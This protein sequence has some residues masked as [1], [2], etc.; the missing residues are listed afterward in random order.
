MIVK[1]LVVGNMQANCYIIENDDS[2]II[3]DPGAEIS[4]IKETITKEVKGVL[5][6]HSHTDHTGALGNIIHE[7]NVKINDKFDGFDYEIIDTKGH[8]SDSKSFYFPNEGIMFTGD[9]LF[10]DS[11]GRLDLGGNN[12]DMINS[13]N[14]IVKYPLD[15]KIYPGHGEETTIFNEL[16]NIDYFT[17]VLSS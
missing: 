17:S 3:V 4:K 13:L 16:D 14:K 9:F 2:C 15:T 11:I 7:Y 1:K 8:T 6:T 5:I 12:R 10:K